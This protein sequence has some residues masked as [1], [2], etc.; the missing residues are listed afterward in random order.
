MTTDEHTAYV[1]LCKAPTDPAAWQAVAQ[2]WHTPA[3]RRWAFEVARLLPLVVGQQT[4]CLAWYELY[5]AVANVATYCDLYYERALFEA[6]Y[7]LR[8]L[9][10]ACIWLDGVRTT[11]A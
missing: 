8:R 4:R 11:V 7:V 1:G 6:V 5:T 9:V 2:A 10:A 3:I